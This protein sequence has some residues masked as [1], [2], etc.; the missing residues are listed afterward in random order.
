MRYGA[1]GLVGTWRSAAVSMASKPAPA[2]TG[3]Y[4]PT[5]FRSYSCEKGVDQRAF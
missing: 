5:P 2:K 1:R 3:R 4:N